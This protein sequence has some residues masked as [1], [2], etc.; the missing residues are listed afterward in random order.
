MARGLM[1]WPTSTGWLVVLPVAAAVCLAICP[2]HVLQPEVARALVR[3]VVHPVQ[4]E[5]MTRF[6]DP[7]RL[8][9]GIIVIKMGVP[10]G[11]LTLAAIIWAIL[12][13]VDNEGLSILSAVTVLY[14]LLLTVLPA[15]QTYYLMSIYPPM[16]LLLA[17][18]ILQVGRRL[19]GHD[20]LMS[21][22]VALV[23]TSCLYLAW[24]TFR[25]YPEFGYYGHA[26]IGNKWLGAESRG[27]RNLVQ[28]TNDGTYDALAWLDAHVPP[29][30]RVVSYLWD[31]H[32]ID[33]FQ[34]AHRPLYQLV[35]R[36]A[37]DAR[38]RPPEIDDA[39]FVVVGLNNEVSYHDMPSER[40]LLAQFT[41][42][43][44]IGRGRGM[45]RMPVIS[46]FERKKPSTATAH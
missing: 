2:A 30:R 20:R 3:A 14:I 22:W 46:I 39:D 10:L 31:D 38:N 32:V 27:Y 16:V 9:L 4:A 44:A 37:M 21:A 45:S 19:H 13:S 17:A 25:T 35:R 26:L 36:N 41:P 1:R 7:V 43:H 18:F 33:E 42:V 6:V 40:E 34:Q 15:R 8:Y 24:G 11:L 29:G 5:A 12:R 23:V 28:V